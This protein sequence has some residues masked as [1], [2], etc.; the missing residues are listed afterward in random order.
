MRW[1]GN[2][3]K[4]GPKSLANLKPWPKGVSGNPGGRRRKV[5]T[6]GL[7]DLLDSNKVGGLVLPEGRT[8]REVILE[9]IVR[10]IMSG[11]AKTISDIWERFEGKVAEEPT[12]DPNHPLVEVL[13][14]IHDA[15]ASPR[16]LKGGSKAKAKKRATRESREAV[17]SKGKH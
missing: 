7:L 9:G 11:N 1:I 5:I 3:A 17:R 13:R 16:A 10:N 15:N 12:G 6:E 2:V 4:P 14:A 8:L